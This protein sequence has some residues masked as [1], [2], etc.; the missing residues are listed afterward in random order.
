M[1]ALFAVLVI[2]I[3]IQFRDAYFFSHGYIVPYLAKNTMF[4]G[5][6]KLF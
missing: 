3:A 4:F 1:L 5:G 2:V 6:L